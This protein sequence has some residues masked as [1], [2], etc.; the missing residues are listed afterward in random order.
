MRT[1]IE[2]K[3]G[4]TEEV[5]DGMPVCSVD[6]DTVVGCIDAESV[7]LTDDVPLHLI[8]RIIFEND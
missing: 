3:D 8:A 7:C 1:L 5:E 4:H 2:F 6:S